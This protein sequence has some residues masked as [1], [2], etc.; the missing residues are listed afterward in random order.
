MSAVPSVLSLSR[1]G[2]QKQSPCWDE[3]G[4]DNRVKDM[5]LG[6]AAPLSPTALSHGVGDRDTHSSWVMSSSPSSSC[7]S[8]YRTIG[9]LHSDCICMEQPPHHGRDVPTPQ[10]S[11]SVTTTT[12]KHNL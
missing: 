12:P 8:W 1:P 6:A 10:T 7:G 11:H 4:W 3:M 2:R 9:R 5:R